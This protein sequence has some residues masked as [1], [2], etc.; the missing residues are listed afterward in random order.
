MLLLASSYPGLNGGSGD[1]TIAGLAWGRSSRIEGNLTPWQEKG[2]LAEK[3]NPSVGCVFF[4]FI[5]QRRVDV[6]CDHDQKVPTKGKCLCVCL[7]VCLCVTSLSYL[8]K[9]VLTPYVCSDT[10]SRH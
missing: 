7:S 8:G 5:D 9:Y 3:Q 1:Y 2:H 10:L 6:L 4:L